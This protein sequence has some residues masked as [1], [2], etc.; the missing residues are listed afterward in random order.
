MISPRQIA[1]KRF[2]LLLNAFHNYRQAR[3][4]RRL[5]AGETPHGFRFIG[6]DRMAS[7]TF[8]PDETA[9]I[10][11]FSSPGRVYVD[12]GA[13]YGY[14]VCL[15]RARGADVV[16]IEPLSDNLSLLY[17][18]LETNGWNDVEVFP[19]GVSSAPRVATLYGGGTAASLLP[20]WAGTSETFRRSI[21]LST[22]DIVLGGPRFAGREMLVKID[23]EGVEY[24][25]LLGAS[26]TL[27]RTPRPKW[28]LEIC[29]TELHPSGR[30]PH[31]LETFEL[32]WNHGYEAKS[33]SAGNRVV[34]RDEVQRWVRT[35]QRDYGFVAYLFE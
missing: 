24:D 16:A 19:L 26:E 17:A 8:E 25:V 35:G 23:V 29:L 2:P 13:N 28:V 5:K 11:G 7:G 9:A 4:I 34:T 32:F 21:A 10:A 30:N 33:I 3:E 20:N 14:Y 15:A 18:N 12:V 22:L 31:F 1:R 27:S 6:N